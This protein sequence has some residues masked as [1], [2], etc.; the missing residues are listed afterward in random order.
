[1]I[2]GVEEIRVGDEV[3]AFIVRASISEAPTGFLTKHED[4]FQ[5]GFI[6]YPLGHEI[7]AHR[8]PPVKRSVTSTSEVLHVRSG[9]VRVTWY[10]GSGRPVGSRELEPGDLLLNLIGGHS[11]DMLEETTLL[12]IK[13]GPYAGARD[14]EPIA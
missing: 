9:R 5:L 8:H 11:F 2:D 13:Q 7:V 10:D 6:H 3:H 1:M 14:K 12:E 4:P